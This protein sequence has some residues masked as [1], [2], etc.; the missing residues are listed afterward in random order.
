VSKRLGRG[1]QGVIN[2]AEDKNMR[3]VKTAAGWIYDP[4]SVKNFERSYA[5]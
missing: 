1:R 4:H 2:M 5:T 3:A